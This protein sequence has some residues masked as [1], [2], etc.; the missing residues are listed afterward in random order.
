MKNKK[1]K[2]LKPKMKFNPGMLGYEPDVSLKNL[3]KELKEK[4]Q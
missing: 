1:I 4:K 2:Y 3:K